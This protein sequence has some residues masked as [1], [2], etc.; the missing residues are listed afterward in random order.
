MAELCYHL[1][2]GPEQERVTIDGR[3][4]QHFTNR[5][6]ADMEV[7]IVGVVNEVHATDDVQMVILSS[8]APD[9]PTGRAIFAIQNLVLKSVVADEAIYAIPGRTIS[10]LQSWTEMSGRANN[11]EGV[12]YIFLHDDDMTESK[13]VTMFTASDITTA[14][15]ANKAPTTIDAPNALEKGALLLCLARPLRVDAPKEDGTYW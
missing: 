12:T 5:T 1:D 4:V 10:D 2:F 6:G 7:R 15:I 9:N 13:E 3:F 11:V 8:P 14:D